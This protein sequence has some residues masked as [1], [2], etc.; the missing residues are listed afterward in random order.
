MASVSLLAAVPALLLLATVAALIGRRWG[1]AAVFGT[2]CMVTA[3]IG[4]LDAALAVRAAGDERNRLRR[5]LLQDTHLVAHALAGPAAEMPHVLTEFLV[6]GEEGHRVRLLGPA[7]ANDPLAAAALGVSGD[8]ATPLA[9]GEGFAAAARLPRS[10]SAVVLVTADP[11]P[12]QERI[13]ARSHWWIVSGLI[14]HGLCGLGVAASLVMRRILG[15]QRRQQDLMHACARVA[16]ALVDPGEPGAVIGRVLGEIGPA[17]GADRVSVFRDR[18][19]VD[20]T[21]RMTLV[22]GWSAPGVA[23]LAAETTWNDLPYA[24]GLRRWQEAFAAGRPVAGPVRARPAEEWPIL[25][26]RGARSIAAVPI[27]AGGRTWGW[28]GFEDCRRGRHWDSDALDALALVADAIG[29][30]VDRH[31]NEIALAE[32]KASAE[33]ASR[34]KGEFLA[35]MSHEIRTPLNGILGMCGLLLDTRLDGEQRDFAETIR[36]SGESL[37]SV[38]ND[39]LDLSKVEAGRM[40]LERIPFPPRIALE[41]AAMLLAEKAQAKGLELVVRIDPTL[42]GQLVGDP[43]RLRQIVLNL[44]GNAVKFTSQGEVVISL[45][46][47]GMDGDH[48]LCELTVSDTGMGIPAEALPRLFQPFS[49]AD[50]STTRRFGGTGLGLAIT[51]RL[52]EM[53]R[54]TVQVRSTPGLG[55]VFT[56]RL[57]FLAGGSAESETIYRVRRTVALVVANP[58]LRTAAEELLRGAGCTVVPMLPGASGQDSGANLLLWDLAAGNMAACAALHAR[59]G[60]PPVVVLADLGRRIAPEEQESLGV[61]AVVRKPLRRR[62]LLDALSPARLSSPIMQGAS[63]FCGRRVLVAED[64]GVNQRLVLALLEREGLRVDL[65][66]NGIEAVAAAGR[67]P[68]DLVLMDCLMPEMDGWEAVRAIR[69]R[70]EDGRRTPVVALTASTATDDRDRCREA[71]MDGVLTKPVRAEDLRHVLAAHLRPLPDLDEAVLDR[72]AQEAGPGAVATL[73]AAWGQGVVA[74]LHALEHAAEPAARRQ[75]AHTIRGTALNLGMVQLAAVAAQAES[76][77]EDQDRWSEAKA[78]VTGAVRRAGAAIARRR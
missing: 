48:C 14:L 10:A 76:W 41:D 56:C 77:A 21:L 45:A 70:E 20:G 12:W 36:S 15:Q 18:T 51:R 64:N 3:G 60:G 31:G 26:R 2:W 78:L 28:I 50:A 37:L 42:P 43:G 52:V 8:S 19:D 5:D 66:S 65:A 73:L 75:A 46:R 54:G 17:A 40:D 67:V 29:G 57:A 11:G 22:H 4:L 16:E 35:N 62:A 13:A 69:R 49:Q 68:Y 55:T 71:G 30:A 1:L 38:I 33:E 47:T 34:A 61:Q 27:R 7:D 53:M 9:T 44:A 58:S 74:D 24:P 59:L 63:A 32:A 25:A 23:I 72:L 6:L 39:I